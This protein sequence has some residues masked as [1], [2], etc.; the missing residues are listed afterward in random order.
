MTVSVEGADPQS[1]K[2]LR[3]LK[4]VAVELDE[5]RARLREYEQRATEP[6]AVVG[7]GCRFPGGADG[8]ERL[9]EV[10]SE[11]RDVVSEFPTD[12]GWDV[13]GL[14]DPDPD[15]EGKTYTRWGAF[16]EDA[17]GFDA[18]FFG[19]A[20]GEVLAMDPQ[21]RLML[22]VSW[23]ALEHAGIDPLSLRGSATGVFTGIF[24]ASYGNRDTGGLQGYGLTGTSISVASGRVAYV[25]GLQGPAVSVDTA[26]SSS[27]VAIHWAM[28]SLR[29]GECDLALAGGVTVMGLPSIFVGFSRQRGLAADGRCKAFAAAADGTGWGEGAGVVVLERLSDARRLG[30][31]V[32]AV[33]RGSAVNQDGA[34]NGLTAPNGLAQQR[35]IRAALANARLTAAEV[36][37]VEAHGTATTLGDPIEAQALLATYGQG[38]SSE[39]PLWVGSIKS[40]MG[41]TQ[42]AAGVAGVIKVIQAMR[43]G[44]MPATLHVDAPTPRVDWSS[45]AVSVLT[46]AREWPVVDGRPRRAGV[47]SFGISGTNAHVILEQAPVEVSETTGGGSGLTVLPWVV[48]ARSPEALTAQAGRLLAHVQADPGLDPVDVGSSLAGRSVFEHRA[49]VVGADRQALMRGLAGVAAGDPGAG[50]VIGQ[51]GPVGKTVVVFPGQGSQRIGMGR[52][53]H[54][55]LPV[56]AEAF[57]AV[58]DELDRHLRL[59]LREVVWG[60][61][62]ALLDSTEFAQPAL[63]A[64]EV[65]LFAVLRRWGVQPDFVMGHSVGELSAACVAG[66]LTLADAAMLVVARGRL[67]QALPAGGAMV[68]VAASEEEVLPSLV[69]GVGIAAINAPQSVVIS[70]AQAA[71]TAIADRFAQQGRRVH[72]LAVSHAFHSPLMEPMLEEFAR[73]AARVEAREPQIGLV[74]NVTGELAG[75]GGGLGSSQYGSSHY[76]VEHVRRPVR[77]ADSVRHLQTLGATHLIEVGPGSGLTGSIEQSLAPA[78]AIVVSMLGKDRPEVA[79]VLGASGQLFTTGVPVDWAA[80]FAGSGGRR[81]GLPTYA[82][83]RRRFWETPGGDGPADAA[84]LGLGGTEHPLLGAVVERPDSGGVVLTGRLSLADQPWLADHVVGGVVLFPGAGFVE[85]VIR[86]GDEAGCAV[87]EELVLAAPLVLHPGVAVQ[88]QVV[89]GAAVDSGLR[90]VSVYSRAGQS[91]DWLLNAEGTLGVEAPEARAAAADLSVWPPEGAV[92]VDISDGY[93]QLAERGYAY[94]PAFQGL[95]AIWRRE[96]ELFAEVAAPAG[97]GVAVDGMGMHPAVLDAVLHAL[98]LAIETTE[99]RLPFCWRGVSLHAGGAAR[100]RAR[101]VSAGADAISVELADATGLPVLTV[102]SLVTRPMSAEQLRAAVAAAGGAPDQG[103][104]EVMWS[105]IPLGHNSVD[106]DGEP[107]VLSWADFAA[108]GDGDVGVVVWECGST[109]AQEPSAVGS[110]YAGTHAALEVLQSW[111]GTDRAGTLVVLTHGGVG[112]PRE[113]VS[114]LAAAAV[115]GLVR[116]AQAENPGRIVL[117]DTDTAVDAAVLAELATVGEPQL[118]VRGGDVHAARLAPAPPL[119]APPAGEPAWRLAAGGGGTLEDLVIQPCPEA[120]APLQ[121]GQVRVAVAAV[122]VNFRDVVA[123]LGM[124]PGQA[125]PLGAE[126]AGVATEIGPGVTTVAV[127]DAVMGFLGGAGPLAVVDQQLIVEM[128]R[129]WSFPQAAA[130]PVVFLTALYGLADLAGIRAGE[131][132]LIHAGTGGVGMAAVQLARHWGVEIFVTASRG[133]WDTLRAMGFD[134]DHIGDSRTCEF[135]EKFLAVTE[136]RGVDVVLDSLAGEFVDASLRLLVRGG[137]FLEM[138][139]TD[140]RDAQKIAANYPGVQYRAF[141]LSEAGP[142]R[143]HEMLGEVRELFDAGVL[144]RLPVTTWDVRCAPAA[145]RFMSQA[146]HIGKVVLTMPSALADGLADGTVLITGAT[147]AVGAVLARHMVDAFGVRHLVLASRRGDRAEGAAELAAELTE[148]GARV[149]VVACDVADRDAV[150]GLFARLARE[151]PPV[152][153]VIHAAGVLDDTVI[154]SLTPD[155]MDAVLRAKV[156]AAWNLHEATRDLDLSMFA[157]CSSIAATVGSPGQGNY[158]AANAFLDG[159][160]AHRQAAGLAGISL[161]WGMWEQPGGMTAHLSARDLARMSRSGLA[162]MNPGQALELLD[163]ALAID[164]P[165][166]VATRLDR[167]ALDALV[168]SGGLPPLFSGLARRPRRRQI[169]DTGDAAQSKSALAQRLHGLASS[170]QHDLLVGLVC[171]QAAAVLGRPS[172]EDIDPTA[173]FQDLGFDSLTAVELRNRLKTATGLTLPPT[174]IFDHP[175]PA[176]VADYVG[177]QI[178]GSR[179]P[180]SN[181]EGPRLPESDDEK[182]PVHV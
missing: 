15:A 74:S 140:I 148:A 141:D 81:V 171:L 55:C 114:D 35:V 146:R 56:F 174:L 62:A 111:L 69:E 73:V 182:V 18:G 128:P 94:G 67:M 45:G 7:M 158:A 48:S 150:D 131:S 159:L 160:A 26:C 66:V 64:V 144:H 116:S 51:A 121:A 170:E 59:P 161:A 136:G 17:T 79:S 23:E 49:V 164:S 80:V 153:G 20:P 126:G 142:V 156:D 1:D 120:Q 93:A 52:E 122:G 87:I 143:M 172:P 9:W 168:R 61:D 112:L 40:N 102:G 151:F 12:R 130:V 78:E 149:Q 75:A 169:E 88:V 100:V 21:Q 175:T 83:Q 30:H 42:A 3:Y 113:D 179:N 70:G 13:E 154:T 115:W 167:G 127:G 135:E 16:L 118:L 28:A 110:V 101:F 54:H 180:E 129:G 157:L 147:G 37:V 119:L 98:G 99:T 11:G 155:R 82:F 4:K 60:A 34:S 47:S 32:L 2:L 96:S 90:A 107:T 176:A 8:P 22:E 139:K 106:R 72:R 53:L 14:Y 97:A 29:T 38:R 19:I 84:G 108:A 31:S 137:R 33:V 76:W 145:F 86:A 152:R 44:V 109:G 63:F 132:V 105:P 57:D 25:L 173:E 24:A 43:H 58:A 125:P 178:L 104:L 123:A 133:K 39:R 65:A 89:V 177:L 138:G 165:V 27:L 68:A 71:V 124:Y 117:I 163:A 36:D 92:S 6:I 50:A 85:L 46:E 181:G 10:V 162:P 166:M 91:Q 103:P 41:H 134:D 95:V 77:F 5:A